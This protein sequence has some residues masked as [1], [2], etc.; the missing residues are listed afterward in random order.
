MDRVALQVA[1]I[2][3]KRDHGEDV[4]PTRIAFAAHPEATTPDHQ[5]R[6]TIPA[7]DE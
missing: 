2:D 1:N 6:E 5:E 7:L 4:S 3:R